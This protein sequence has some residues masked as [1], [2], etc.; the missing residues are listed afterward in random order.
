MNSGGVMPGRLAGSGVHKYNAESPNQGRKRFNSI[1]KTIHFAHLGILFIYG[2][3][4]LTH[5]REGGT[6]SRQI[7]ICPGNIS[8]GMRDG[9]GSRVHFN[10]APLPNTFYQDCIGFLFCVKKTIFMCSI[11]LN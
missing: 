1:T 11:Q 10:P 4:S 6:H 7:S 5:I 3:R 9:E 8:T 2:C